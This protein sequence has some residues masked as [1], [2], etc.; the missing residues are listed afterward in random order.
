MRPSPPVSALGNG[1]D[2]TVSETASYAFCAKAWHL[3][4]VLRKHPS[5]P[6]AAARVAGTAAHLVDGQRL[7]TDRRRTTW[8]LVGSIILI[9]AAIGLLV[10]GLSAKW[11]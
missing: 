3:E 4:Y 10:V 2:V 8:L 5:E 6:L 11:K 9:A 7:L 1:N